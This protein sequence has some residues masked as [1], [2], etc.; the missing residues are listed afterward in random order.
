MF[1][2]VKI[3]RKLKESVETKRWESMDDFINFLYTSIRSAEIERG[4]SLHAPDLREYDPAN[5]NINKQQWLS[6]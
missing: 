4:P 5:V 2:G 1:T 3:V 6:V